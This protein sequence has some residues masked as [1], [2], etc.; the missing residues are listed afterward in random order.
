MREKKKI[1]SKPAKY[2]K[3]KKVVTKKSICPRFLLERTLLIV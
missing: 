3:L 2:I 1:H